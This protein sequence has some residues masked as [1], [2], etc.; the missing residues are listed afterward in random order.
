MS[1]SSSPFAL[2]EREDVSS[3]VRLSIVKV[4]P[5]ASEAG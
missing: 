3:N 2:S 5:S 1:V 4:S